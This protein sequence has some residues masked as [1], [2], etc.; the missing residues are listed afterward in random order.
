MVETYRNHPSI[1]YWSLANESQRFPAYR[2]SAKVVKAL[3]PS[4]P[5]TFNWLE[6]DGCDI[7]TV[8]YPGPAGPDTYKDAPAPVSYGEYCHLNVYNRF[9]LA[10]DPGLSDAWGRGFRKMWDAMFTSQGT[11]GGSLWAAMDDTFQMPDGRTV[12]YGSWGLL[13]GWRRRKPIPCPLPS[14]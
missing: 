2:I 11:L 6:E 5:R 14:R 7:T 4:R 9:E 10:A 8:H 13:D 1:L 12:G 3:D